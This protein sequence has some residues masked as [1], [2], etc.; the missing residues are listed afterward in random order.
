ML[1]VMKHILEKR[2]NAND[3]YTTLLGTDCT[4]GSCAGGGGY[5]RLLDLGSL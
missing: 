3:R 2:E 1:F 5:L 4:A